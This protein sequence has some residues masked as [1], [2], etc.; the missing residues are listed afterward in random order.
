[1]LKFRNY[2]IEDLK[3]CPV[4]GLVFN[5]NT[6]KTYSRKIKKGY[7]L[8]Y[9]PQPIGRWAPTH[10]IMAY[11]YLGKEYDDK[12]VVH[13]KNGNKLDNN[14]I[15]LDLLSE[16]QHSKLH[17]ENVSP[18]IRLKISLSLKGRPSKRKGQ[19]MSEEAREN[20]RKAQLK[21][22]AEHKR[23]KKGELKND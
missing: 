7:Y 23:S 16:S 13:H 21:Y 8:N 19:K 18:E 17:N 22:W 14:P 1:M 11:T 3:I 12:K 6:G 5:E 10:Q 9:L 2:E 20:N 15:N 4:T